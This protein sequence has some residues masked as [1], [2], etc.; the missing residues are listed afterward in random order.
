M[1][2]EHRKDSKFYENTI[3][4]IKYEALGNSNILVETFSPSIFTNRPVFRD[5]NTKIVESSLS[6]N[7][8]VERAN[9]NSIQEL[10]RYM[11]ELKRL[12]AHRSGLEKLFFTPVSDTDA[13]GRRQHLIE[14]MR[15]NEI[16][17]C[18]TEIKKVL[19]L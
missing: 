8:F 3:K 12:N 5:L 2:V 15:T 13:P 17:C 1:W 11:N 4:S 19:E 14:R 6:N 18:Q 7:T 16:N 9:E 10:V